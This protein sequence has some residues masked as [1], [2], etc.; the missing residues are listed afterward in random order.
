MEFTPE[1]LASHILPLLP[2][3]GTPVLN[4]VMRVM[5]SRQLEHQ[6]GPEIYF[7]ARDILLKKGK[8]GR[9]RGQNGQIF[10]AATNGSQQP[11]AA[12]ETA[13]PWPE[14][15]LMQPL[16]AYLEGGFRQGLDLPPDS[17]AIVQDTSAKGPARGLWARP[18]FILVSAMRFKYLP[19]AQVDVH[20]FELKTETGCSVLSVHEALA[21]TRYTHFGHLVWHLPEGTKSEAKLAEIENHCAEHGIGLIRMRDPS[22]GDGCEILVDPV[23]KST[24][25]TTIE[26]FLETR[27]TEA[28]KS[29]LIRATQ[30]QR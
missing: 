26:G 9:L 10:L 23:R 5:L 13:A 6:I 4:R 20:S 2:R 12:A 15:K 24:L 8:I 1:A 21:Q 17:V 14:V 11:A 3:D 18:D 28:Q 25:T 30:G 7:A 27:L 29:V 22:A 16:Q 19:G